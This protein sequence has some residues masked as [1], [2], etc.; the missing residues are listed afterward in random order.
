MN[1]LT[2]INGIEW[3][4]PSK[5][6]ENWKVDPGALDGESVKML[7]DAW[8]SR[9]VVGKYFEDAAETI[10]E[11]LTTKQKTIGIVKYCW[12]MMVLATASVFAPLV[13]TFIISLLLIPIQIAVTSIFAYRMIT[14]A[15]MLV[16]CRLRREIDGTT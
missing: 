5:L 16:H 7:L 9:Y 1:R 12:P 6:Y 13:T 4:L 10:E 11:P 3:T 15:M 14:L 2:E 8:H